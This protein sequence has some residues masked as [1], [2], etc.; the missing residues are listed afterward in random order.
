MDTYDFLS[1]VLRELAG[2][3]AMGAAYSSWSDEFARK[4]A[5]M[6]WTDAEVPLR[7][8]RDR[9]VTV[10]ELSTMET[11]ALRALGFGAWD[12]HLTLI[13]LWAW[14]YIADGEVLTC[15]DGE[16]SVK[17]RDDIDLDVRFGC[18][19]HGFPTPAAAAP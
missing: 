14:H 19:A 1:S 13:P 5:R 11:T 7:R 4:E 18:I 12:E 9:K 10:A 2:S 6:V 8:P 3:A 15:I 17:G 16:T